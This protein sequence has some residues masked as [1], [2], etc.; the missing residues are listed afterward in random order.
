MLK[1]LISYNSFGVTA[2]SSKCSNDIFN[3]IIHNKIYP[4]TKGKNK[5]SILAPPF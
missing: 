3:V 4:N 5:F 1:L 2:E